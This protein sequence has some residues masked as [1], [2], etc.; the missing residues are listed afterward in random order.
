[1]PLRLGRTLECASALLRSP[2]CASFGKMCSLCQK[3]RHAKKI[4]KTQKTA[5]SKCIQKSPLDVNSHALVDSQGRQ[6]DNRGGSQTVMSSFLGGCMCASGRL[7]GPAARD[8][9]LNNERTNAGG[10]TRRELHRN[11][12]RTNARRIPD[13]PMTW[14]VL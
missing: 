9:W 3:R 4:K 6:T 1:M 2:A 14:P 7:P 10:P 8:R 13:H 12:G 11:G 5:T